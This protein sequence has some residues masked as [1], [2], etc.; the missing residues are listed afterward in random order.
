MMV[1][2]ISSEDLPLSVKDSRLVYACPGRSG[3][4]SMCAELIERSIF[5]GLLP[6]ARAPVC[7]TGEQ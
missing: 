1:M 3:S 2:I 6:C 5:A 4:I 7:K